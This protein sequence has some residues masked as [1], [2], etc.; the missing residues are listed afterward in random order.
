MASVDFD[1]WPNHQVCSQCNNGSLGVVDLQMPMGKADWRWLRFYDIWGQR[2]G[3]IAYVLYVLTLWSAQ[4]NWLMGISAS[5]IT[6]N[7]QRCSWRNLPHPI[8]GSPPQHVCMTDGQELVQLQE[9]NA[10]S[11]YKQRAL[12]EKAER[13]AWNLSY[14][15]RQDRRAHKWPNVIWSILFPSQL[16]LTQRGTRWHSQQTP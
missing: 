5:I 16:P 7:S 15:L 1:F 11:R 13:I 3:N 6:R 10:N 4:L 9:P 2:L 12:R 14:L 8:S